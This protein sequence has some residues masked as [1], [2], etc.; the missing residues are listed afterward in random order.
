MFKLKS[1]TPTQ[2]LSTAEAVK[3][4]RKLSEVYDQLGWNGTLRAGIA[5]ETE[6]GLSSKKFV[7]VPT[8][9]IEGVTGRRHYV[10]YN[11]S[12]LLASN[13]DET[14]HTSKN[15]V[16]A[17]AQALITEYEAY[18][19][20][21]AGYQKKRAVFNEAEKIY[22]AIGKKKPTDLTMD[23]I[24]IAEA[25]APKR[26]KEPST[27]DFAINGVYLHAA[28]HVTSGFKP[29]DSADN[30]SEK[31][32]EL[33]RVCM[34]LNLREFQ[35]S[36]ADRNLSVGQFYA[37]AYTVASAWRAGYLEAGE[38]VEW[39]P[40]EVALGTDG[41]WAISDIGAKYAE[42]DT[43]TWKV[44]DT[45]CPH[46]D[47]LND[48]LIEIASGIVVASGYNHYSLNHTTGGQKMQGPMAPTLITNS[49]YTF[50]PTGPIVPLA[51]K[52][53][54]TEIDQT[55]LFYNAAHPVN[56]R[57]VAATCIPTSHVVHFVCPAI[58]P[59]PLFVEKDSFLRIRE[60]LVPS[61]AHKVYVASL[62]FARVCESG[63]A[64]FL[65]WY[66][67]ADVFQTMME[68]IARD[69]AR[70]HPGSRYYTDQQCTF[71]QSEMDQYLPDL[72]YFV[73]QRMRLST[74]AASPHVSASHAA[75]ADPQWQGIVDM[76]KVEGIKIVDPVDFEKYLGKIGQKK[77]VLDLKDESTWSSAQARMSEWATRIRGAIGKTI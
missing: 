1:R 36:Y 16:H 28:T 32:T 67:E 39:I 60:R 52:K 3:P 63:L 6:L 31:L 20:A 37:A 27:S 13:V 38:D 33:Y 43:K 74:I 26:P 50:E 51:G 17:N 66:N 64:P 7:L 2:D 14:V 54:P 56:K 72:A 75:A 29:N 45:I 40:I 41:Q 68:T 8:L 10:V 70:C 22:E 4:N 61:G 46:G 65:P 73:S 55:N 23:E 12:F 59:P 47:G 42:R 21:Y 69:G 11:D 76:S 9:N 44:G 25:G 62:V 77:A 71:S 34:E 57:A 48:K 30:N 15:F 24:A 19:V 53:H 35:N 5:T 49:L 58:C 18:I